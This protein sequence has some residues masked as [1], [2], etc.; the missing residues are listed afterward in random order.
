MKLK[1]LGSLSLFVPKG[2]LK[3]NLFMSP[4]LTLNMPS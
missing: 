3:K 4:I 1:S 2:W